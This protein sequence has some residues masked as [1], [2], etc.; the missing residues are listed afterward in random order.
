MWDTIGDDFCCLVV[1]AFSTMVLIKSLN[2]G[3][4]K[5]IS[6]NAA[7]DSIGR[8]RP[9]TLLSVA[10]EILDRAMALYICTIA[11]K[12]VQQEQLRFVPGQFILDTVIL[13]W[14][15]MEWT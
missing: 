4:T 7:T 12:V 9:I 1:E 11:R 5:L 15:A 8:W 6:Q 14:E 3:L 2:Q 10:F 13:S